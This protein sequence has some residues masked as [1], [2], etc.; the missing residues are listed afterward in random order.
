MSNILGQIAAF[1]RPGSKL[2]MDY[3]GANTIDLAQHWKEAR[4]DVMS[5]WGEPWLFGV[6]SLRATEF[7]KENGFE[8]VRTY[9]I[10][11]PDLIKR[12]ALHTNGSVYGSAVFQRLREA[13]I[14]QR[15]ASPDSK[16]TSP[17]PLYWLA[18]MTH[19]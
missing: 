5:A 3:S 16:P 9:P 1:G 15:G 12:Y 7:F 6:P 11:D 17:P 2:V 18:E 4:V 8:P 13:A 14:A 10:N 19:H